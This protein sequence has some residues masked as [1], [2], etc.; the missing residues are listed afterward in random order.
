MT[1]INKTAQVPY[2]AEQMYQLVDDVEKYPDFLPWC[3]NV[4]ILRQ[5]DAEVEAQISMALGKLQQS[6]TTRNTGEPPVR[7]RMDL[8]EGPF[9]YLHGRW[10]FE[11]A[12]SGCRVSLDMDFEFKNKLV[13]MALG[14]AFNKIVNSLMS[15]FVQ[16]AH[17]LYG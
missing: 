5:M 14:G 4:R 6:F 8:L 2:S 9:Q 11:P 12:G 10:E 3:S 7:L 13:R 17:Q 16:R 15:A 1:Q